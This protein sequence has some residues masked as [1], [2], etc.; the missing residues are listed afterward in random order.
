MKMNYHCSRCGKL[1]AEEVPVRKRRSKEHTSLKELRACE[2]A[3]LREMGTG[4]APR[5]WCGCGML[6]ILVKGSR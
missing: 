4:Q 5:V 3:E 1:M 2:G 6:H